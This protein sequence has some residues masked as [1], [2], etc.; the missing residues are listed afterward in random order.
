MKNKILAMLLTVII[1]V[2]AFGSCSY[3]FGDVAEQGD[4]TVV[5][6]NADGTY[7][8]YKTYLEN[9]ENKKQGAVGVI[10]NLRDRDN[11]PLLVEM[12]DTGYGPF[13]TSIGSLKADNGAKT[14]VAFYTSLASDSYEGASTVTYGE[15]TLYYSGYGLSGMTVKEGTVILFRLESYQ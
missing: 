11:N 13:V 14:Y 2:L 5:I 9:V 3:I 8:V 10:E 6:E 15:M 1:A 12:D 7:D 4:V